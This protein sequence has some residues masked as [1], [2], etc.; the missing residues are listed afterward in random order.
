M[1]MKIL[2]I[3]VEGKLLVGIMEL[4]DSCVIVLS[5]SNAKVAKLPAFTETKIVTY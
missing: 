5:R 4:P 2:E 1:R 3:N